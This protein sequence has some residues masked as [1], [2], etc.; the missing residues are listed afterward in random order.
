[1]NIWVHL[2]FQF[3]MAHLE[4]NIILVCFVLF[5]FFFFFVINSFSFTLKNQK[6]WW[7]MMKWLM[8]FL[9]EMQLLEVLLLV[10]KHRYIL[11]MIGKSRKKIKFLLG[12]IQFPQT[13]CNNEKQLWFGV[14]LESNLYVSFVIYINWFANKILV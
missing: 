8:L 5:F 4:T 6:L 13:Q 10:W 12:S 9:V 2:P 14:K 7:K 1:M 11:F 3:P